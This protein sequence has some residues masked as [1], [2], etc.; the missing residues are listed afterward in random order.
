MNIPLMRRLDRWIGVPL[1]LALTMARKLGDL[2]RRF[3]GRPR[4]DPVTS[5][6]LVKLTEMGSTVLALPAIRQLQ[7]LYPGAQFHYICL[8]GNQAVLDLFPD[9][10]FRA[11]PI[12]ATSIWRMLC[13]SF[14][15]IR[16][17]RRQRV[18]V[19]ISLELFSRAAAALVYL[20]R[21]RVRVA[22][23]RFFSAG[24]NCGDLY[25]HRVQFSPYQHMST[26]FLVLVEASAESESEV[27]LLKKPV[28][29]VSELPPMPVSDEEREMVLAKL[30]SQGYP[31]QDRPP[32][33]VFNVNSSD[34]FP[35]RR[36]PAE[37]FEQLLGRCLEIHPDWWIVLTGAA[38]EKSENARLQERLRSERLITLAG[39]TT[40]RELVVLFG[41]GEVLVANDSGPAQFAA[42]SDISIVSLFGPETPLLYA[43]LS[44]HN[45]SLS[46]ELACS[47][48]I[49]AFNHRHSP[50]S[51]NV[52]MQSITVEQVMRTIEQVFSQRIRPLPAK[53]YSWDN[54]SIRTT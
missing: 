38:H 18:D 14:C 5:V 29:P 15:V 48:C 16:A 20:S 39:E 6:L 28:S 21:A 46:A 27:P 37:R 2:G 7:K 4:T 23:E 41:L 26:A 47:P 44:P 10:P 8:D 36:W 13:D 51:D 12:R 43:P 52:C 30:V 1:C 54:S 25:T 33:L 3:W 42:L 9:V 11:Y 50:C 49:S 53:T 45:Q 40:L 34:L 31:R 19:A 22:F 35:L 17:V 32:L 24:G